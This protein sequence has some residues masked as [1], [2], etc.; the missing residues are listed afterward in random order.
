MKCFNFWIATIAL[1]TSP[2]SGF[3]QKKQGIPFAVPFQPAN[4]WMMVPVLWSEAG[5]TVP[6]TTRALRDQYF[7]TLIG[8]PTPLTVQTRGR[9]NSQRER[10]SARKKRFLISL[11]AQLTLLH[12]SLP[13]RFLAH[14]GNPYTP[15]FRCC[16]TILSKTNL[17]RIQSA[18]LSL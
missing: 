18:R 11:I 15:R 8:F 4:D 7:D 12:L 14:P 9:V 1:A 3:G 17:Y 10:D 5:D 16:R 13:S 2:C 6:R